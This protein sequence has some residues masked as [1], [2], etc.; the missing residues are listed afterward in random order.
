MAA[1]AVLS[2]MPGYALAETF[3]FKPTQNGYGPDPDLLDPVVP[4]KRTMTRHQLSQVAVLGDL[5]LPATQ[6]APA[7]S[8]LGIP[9]FV[10]EWVSAPYPEQ[11]ADRPVILNGLG[12]V[13]DEARRRFGNS[14]LE[15]NGRQQLQILDGIAVRNRGAIKTEQ[16]KF[17]HKLRYLVVGAY[18]TNQEGF[19]DIGYVGNVPMES[20]P[21]PTAEEIAILDK[22]LKKLGL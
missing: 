14:Y 21:P 20:Y 13:D 3:A 17:F 11:L 19:D 8:V 9:D 5:I 2:V 7:P 12:W 4:W 16:N 10:D 1:T 22:E 6:D 15:A 18:Y